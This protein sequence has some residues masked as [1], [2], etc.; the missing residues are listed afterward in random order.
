MPWRFLYITT[1][2]FWV[3]LLKNTRIIEYKPYNTPIANLRSD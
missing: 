3:P 2:V 1:L